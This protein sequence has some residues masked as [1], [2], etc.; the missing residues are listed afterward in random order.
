MPINF[1]TLRSLQ[2][3]MKHEGLSASTQALCEDLYVKLRE[4]LMSNLLKHWDLHRSFWEHYDDVSGNGL[5]S[6]PF[7]GWTALI[8]N[9][10]SEQYSL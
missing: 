8:L 6:Q 9:I 2:H 7:T 3:Y 4:N 10:M 5:R 1:L